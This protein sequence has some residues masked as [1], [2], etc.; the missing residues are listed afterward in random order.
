[1]LLITNKRPNNNEIPFI[2]AMRMNIKKHAFLVYRSLS[3]SHCVLLER[4]SST[5][6]A[7]QFI[8]N[9]LKTAFFNW[10]SAIP[11]ILAHFSCFDFW[12]YWDFLK[13]L[14]IF[15]HFHGNFP[16]F[17]TFLLIL[18]VL[19]FSCIFP[20]FVISTVRFWAFFFFVS[21]ILK[22][23]WPMF[24]TLKN[25]FRRRKSIHWMIGGRWALNLNHVF[26]TFSSSRSLCTFVNDDV[27][28]SMAY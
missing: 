14:V 12:F 27:R 15:R 7:N 22:N 3:L 17:F 19:S 11:T 4:I 8:T 13:F 2:R 25:A 26:L 6:I 18:L 23:N 24:W 9:C 21:W 28:I 1:M 20:R 10:F 5:Q 16:Y